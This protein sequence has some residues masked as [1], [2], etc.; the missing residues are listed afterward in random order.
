MELGSEDFSQM[1]DEEFTAM[2]RRSLTDHLAKL[3]RD[4]VQQLELIT[5]L[6]FKLYNLEDSFHNSDCA[7]PLSL[8]TQ[9]LM[10]EP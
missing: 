8:T 6:T 10:L 7:A 3:Q 2:T 5:R 1:S 9:S 4:R